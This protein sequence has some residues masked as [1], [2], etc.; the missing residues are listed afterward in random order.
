MIREK[1]KSIKNSVTSQKILKSE[2]EIK[3]FP[4]KEN[5]E[6]CCA[7]IEVTFRKYQ[8]ESSKIK[9]KSAKGNIEAI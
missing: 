9:L 3:T 8:K 7:Y 6:L 2:E 1:R 4:D 5:L